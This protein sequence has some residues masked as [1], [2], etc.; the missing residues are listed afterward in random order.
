MQSDLKVEYVDTSSLIPYANNSKLH[1]AE[2]VEQIA[3]SIREFGNCDPIAVWT[4]GDGELEIVEGHGRLMALNELGI[5]IAPIIKLDHLTDEQRRAYSHIHNQTTLTSELDLEKLEEDMFELDFDWGSFGFEEFED[6]GY[7]TDFE[8]PDEDAPQFKT[9]SMHLTMEQYDFMQD[10][11]ADIDIDSCVIKGGN[12]IGDK[13]CE[14][15]R[16]W[17]EQRI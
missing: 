7:G 4:N 6:I 16:Q 14:V 1:P 17:A 11:L 8:L 13:V 15:I 5:D 10:N 3:N 12:S 9:V 2:Q